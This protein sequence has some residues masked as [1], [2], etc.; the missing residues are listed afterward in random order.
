MIYENGKK[1]SFQDINKIFNGELKRKMEDNIELYRYS[2][3]KFIFASILFI[4]ISSFVIILYIR[5]RKEFDDSFERDKN[6][7]I[8]ANLKSQEVQKTTL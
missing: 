2:I 6:K 1:S 8:H 3:L 7:L 5:E 4:L